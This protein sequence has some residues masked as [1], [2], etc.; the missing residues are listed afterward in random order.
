M[1]SSTIKLKPIRQLRD[2]VI[3]YKASGLSAGGSSDNFLAEMNDE[4]FPSDSQLMYGLARRSGNVVQ[5]DLAGAFVD[6]T[7]SVREIIM[8]L[9]EEVQTETQTSLTF[10]SISEDDEWLP[11]VA[12]ISGSL[13]LVFPQGTRQFSASFVYLVSSI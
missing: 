13:M 11:S 3:E 4:G 9:P 6:S 12:M 5:L 10:M 2:G 7:T 8:E 1:T